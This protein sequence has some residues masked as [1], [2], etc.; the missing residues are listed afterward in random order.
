[1]DANTEKLKGTQKKTKI[2]EEC[3]T[4]ETCPK[5]PTLLD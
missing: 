2:T 4:M 3:D 1:M 5:A